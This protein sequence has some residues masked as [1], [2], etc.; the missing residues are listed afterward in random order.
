MPITPLNLGA[1]EGD[2]TGTKGRNGGQI[3]NDNFTLLENIDI[4]QDILIGLNT[5]HRGLTNNPHNVLATQITDF[6]D[7]VENHPDVAAN[8]TH[9]GETAWNIHGNTAT[10]SATEPLVVDEA[11]FLIKGAVGNE[12]AEIAAGGTNFAWIP[13]LGSL[14]ATTQT[15]TPTEVHA[16][17]VLIGKDITSAGATNVQIGEDNTTSGFLAF[18]N[19]LIGFNLLSENLGNTIVGASNNILGGSKFA[20]VVGN[21]NVVESPPFDGKLSAL[22]LGHYLSVGDA[23]NCG[24][25]GVGNGTTARIHNDIGYSLMLGVGIKGEP[26]VEHTIILRNKRLG[27]VLDNPLSTLD[28][29]GSTGYKYSVIDTWPHTVGANEDELVFLLQPT[30]NGEDFILPLISTIDRRI[31]FLKNTTKYNVNIKAN[32]ADLI[33]NGSAIPVP[34]A[35]FGMLGGVSIQLQAETD[36]ATDTWWVL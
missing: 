31:Y 17:N 27:I 26:T 16:Q 21:N 28:V 2:G 12:P 24:V 25:I 6:D 20:A 11:A 14:V 7:E 4:A 8:T 23:P 22:V 10:G 33:D 18:N 1:A 34:S 13:S 35:S 3:I 5:D 36:S 15:S 19:T 32:V 9:R 29:A 30:Q